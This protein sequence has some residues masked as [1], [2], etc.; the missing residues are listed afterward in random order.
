[1]MDGVDQDRGPF[2]L[3]VDG[4]TIAALHGLPRIYGSYRQHAGLCDEFDLA[5]SEGDC[6]FV[7]VTRDEEPWPRLA[8]A[9][10]YQPCGPGF[11]PGVAFVPETAVLFVGAGTRLLAYALS[12]RPERLWVDATNAG[13]W[14]WSV[15]PSAVLMAAELEF[16]AWTRSGEKLW[17]AFVEPPWSYQVAAERIQ[18]DVMG[19]K[20]EFP[21]ISGPG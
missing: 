12:G 20:T 7:A 10:R 14:Q 8:V 1:M 18:L 15:H 13:F 21:V 17:S 9:E 6:Y 16:A 5:S 11:S 3:A 2:S 4:W 19:N